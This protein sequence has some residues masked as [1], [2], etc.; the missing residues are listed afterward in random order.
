LGIAKIIEYVATNQ[1]NTNLLRVSLN[2]V[3]AIGCIVFAFLIGAVSGILPA[4]Q[5]SKAN[6]VESLRYE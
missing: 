5:A 4:L 6:T 2:P 1:L 3:V